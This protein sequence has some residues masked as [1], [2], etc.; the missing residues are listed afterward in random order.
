MFDRFGRMLCQECT[1][2]MNT[3]TIEARS[4]E[5]NLLA[6]FRCP[7][8]RHVT[9]VEMRSSQPERRSA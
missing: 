5:G 9:I 7:Q 8:C 3:S 1:G 2:V 6:I 4:R